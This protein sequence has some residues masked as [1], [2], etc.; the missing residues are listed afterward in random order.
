MRAYLKNYRQSPRKVRLLA[1][2]I[3]GKDVDK[4]LAEVSYLPK[5]AALPMKKLI[6][7]AAANAKENFNMEQ[8]D[9]MVKDVT[10]DQGF[11]LKRYMPRAFGRASSINKRTSNISIT[12][13]VKEPQKEQK[14]KDKKQATSKA[15]SARASKKEVGKKAVKKEEKE[16]KVKAVTEKKTNNLKPKS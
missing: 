15:T 3:R 16:T 1:G 13:S 6:E 10:V 2:F 8:K 5:R 9:L 14:T 11:T 4:A 12:L 7:S